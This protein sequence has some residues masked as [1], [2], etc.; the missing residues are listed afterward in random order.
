MG[1]LGGNTSALSTNPASIGIYRSSEL[2]VTPML[3]LGKTFV[4]PGNGRERES[5]RWNFNIGN[6]GWV[7]VTNLDN[8]DAKDKWKKIQF[9]VAYNR[10]N[11]F[12]NRSLY[13]QTVDLPFLGVLENETN[14][15][16][17]TPPPAPGTLRR[18]A[19]N[20]DL[21]FY[22]SISG[23]FGTD[24][25]PVRFDDDGNIIQ[26]ED[27]TQMQ[28]VRTSGAQHEWAISFGGNYGDVLFVGAT[29]GLP[30][31]RYREITRFEERDND[32][33]HEHFTYWEYDEDLQVNGNGVNFKI[34][35]IVRPAD[36]L[37]VGFSFQTRTRYN[38]RETHDQGVYGVTTYTDKKNRQVRGTS[39]EYLIRTPMRLT[40][41]VGIVIGTKGLIGVEYEY[42]NY[43]NMSLVDLESGQYD[44]DNEFI[45]KNYTNG[46]TIRV[47]AEYRLD[48]IKLRGGYN[49]TMTP[50]QNN[51]TANFS[52]HTFSAGLGINMS[53]TATLDL[54][55]VNT[56]R[57]YSRVPYTE[58]P[59]NQYH[60][61]GHQFV[62][63]LGWRF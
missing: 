51:H 55:Y 62:M 20:A 15:E 41:S 33:L 42:L 26:Y 38:I 8:S 29:L 6:F 36:F 2:S 21:I 50:Y 56:S 45:S 35:A 13:I 37:R 11:D 53:S 7:G 12:W 52:G 22:D 34:G 39:Y 49:Y 19:Y 4:T 25:T 54:G 48:P 16:D 63:T 30:V 57:K 3:T 40:G 10:L 5:E 1:A 43:A 27:L 23:W 9:G 14:K 47:G 18:M 32:N 31:V 58:M 44:V 60:T 46:G 59:R 24:L 61:E 28:S 17:W